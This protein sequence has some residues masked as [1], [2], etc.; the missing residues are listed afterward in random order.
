LDAAGSTVFLLYNLES[1]PGPARLLAEIA[2]PAPAGAAPLLRIGRIAFPLVILASLDDGSLQVYRYPT[3]FVAGQGH[4]YRLPDGPAVF[5]A[6]NSPAASHFF[7]GGPASQGL[8]LLELASGENKIVAEI[9]DAYAQHYLLPADASAIIL[10]H[11]DSQPAVFA[12]TVAEGQRHD[13]GA[14]RSCQRIPDKVALSADGTALII[15]CDS[16][17]HIWRVA[18][19]EGKNE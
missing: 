9:G 11:V 12:W 18:A 3:A 16:G 4:R 14:Y 5:G 2:F 19:E 7:W 10:V 8:N 13:L 15:G 17:L 6:L 1:G